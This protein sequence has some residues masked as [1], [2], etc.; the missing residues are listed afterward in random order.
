M[1]AHRFLLPLGPRRLK[2]RYANKITNEKTAMCKMG[3]TMRLSTLTGCLVY[4]CCVFL[5]FASI[6]ANA[7]SKGVLS[8]EALLDVATKL[9]LLLPKRVDKDTELR[10]VSV[11]KRTL[12][13]NYYLLHH[14]VSEINQPDF[15]KKMKPQITNTAC[16]SPDLRP[17]FEEDTSVEYTYYGNDGVFI[18]KIPVTPELC[19]QL[20]LFK[21][22]FEPGH[23]PANKFGY[24]V[25]K[26]NA[27]LV[28]ESLTEGANPNE[29]FDGNP[30]IYMA[31]R[32]GNN[33]II[34]VLLEFGADINAKT[35]IAGRT[36]LHEA[37]LQGHLSTVKL[38]LER[39]ADVNA[40]NKHGRTPLYYAV[41][42]PPPLSRP[43]NSGEVAELL[44][45]HGGK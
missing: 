43:K 28:R 9:N 19:K 16:S 10:N 18:A 41:S 22:H 6:E 17:L 11:R 38:L 15:L 25:V 45:R 37:A 34:A 1:T 14:K 7:E 42:P 32:L 20:G 13:Y 23:I 12:I 2:Q 24:G 4:S 31:A 27:A 36:A 30:A 33:N 21:P 29:K 3:R 5:K 8:D 35:E 26:N 40:R 39:G 44:R